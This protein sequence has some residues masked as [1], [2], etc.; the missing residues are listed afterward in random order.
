M[1]IFI[2]FWYLCL[3]FAF[4]VFSSLF[5]VFSVFRFY[6]VV[7]S[8]L[9]ASSCPTHLI[10]HDLTLPLFL[11]LVRK[12]VYT[13]L[14]KAWDLVAPY[15]HAQYFS[16]RGNKCAPTILVCMWVV[17]RLHSDVCTGVSGQ[18]LA[19]ISH[20]VCPSLSVK[21]LFLGVGKRGCFFLFLR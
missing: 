4:T 9:T 7:N 6:S 11:L 19:Y 1:F 3:Y 13:K 10:A 16:A 2:L 5:S 17:A 21:F 15:A 12:L 18:K 8:E 14:D 20:L